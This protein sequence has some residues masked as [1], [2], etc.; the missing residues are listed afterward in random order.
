MW[1]LFSKWWKID[2]V[3][4]PAKAFRRQMRY[5]FLRLANISDC[6]AV[7][8]LLNT[9]LIGGHKLYGE[10]FYYNSPFAKKKDFSLNPYEHTAINQRVNVQHEQ[11]SSS[12]RHNRS[13]AQ[14]VTSN[15][16]EKR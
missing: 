14:M 7:L 11:P 13:Y 8:Q 5:R 2:E 4:I 16:P 10:V 6:K 3:F 1:N 15:K 12:L 9:I